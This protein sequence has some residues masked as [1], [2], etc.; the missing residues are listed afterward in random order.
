[1][2]YRVP[3]LPGNFLPHDGHASESPVFAPLAGGAGAG[4]FGAGGAGFGADGAALG[5]GGFAA[6][7]AGFAG[8]GAGR[9]GAAR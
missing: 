4:G 8:A 1:M 6:G 7:G 3:G 2:Q 9:E 5:T